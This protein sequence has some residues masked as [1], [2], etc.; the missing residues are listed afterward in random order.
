MHFH[1]GG[2][3][4]APCASGCWRRQDQVTPGTLDPLA[5]GVV[6]CC[7]GRTTKAV[8]GLMGMSKIY[9]ATV[10]LSAFTDTDDREGTRQAH[11]EWEPVGSAT[12]RRNL[13]RFVGLIEQRPPAHSAVH[14]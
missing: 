2:A 5:I 6:L 3:L 8:P 1:G 13:N 7:L 9:E 10:D 4:C 12:V 11:P 14:I